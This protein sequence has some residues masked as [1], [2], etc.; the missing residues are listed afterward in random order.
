VYPSATTFPANSTFPGLDPA[1]LTSSAVLPRLTS[2]A[3][4]AVTVTATSTAVLP[5]LTSAATADVTV[6]A[7]STAVLPRL[8]S[9]AL[10]GDADPTA[11]FTATA[12]L[13]R[14]ISVGAFTAGTPGAPPSGRRLSAILRDERYRVRLR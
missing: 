9:T 8:T 14:L 12:V 10:I 5:R 4:L 13:P 3:T 7:K 2:A 11:F 6:A 1:N